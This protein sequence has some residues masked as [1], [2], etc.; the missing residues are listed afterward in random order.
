LGTCTIC[1]I[2]CMHTHTHTHVHDSRCVAAVAG[3]CPANA[4]TPAVP[5][6]LGY[7]MRPLYMCTG[8]PSDATCADDSGAC[9]FVPFPGHVGFDDRGEIPKSIYPAAPMGGDP[10]LLVSAAGDVHVGAE[11]MAATTP[12]HDVHACDRGGGPG[13]ERATVLLPQRRGARR[14]LT[15]GR[16]CMWVSWARAVHAS[17]ST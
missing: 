5:L 6:M 4:A 8:E 15:Q 3:T 1:I 17:M 12:P 11:A 13:C 2:A 7:R 16:V 9:D 14:C 10:G